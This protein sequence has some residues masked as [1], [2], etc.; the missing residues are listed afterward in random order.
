[1]T[2]NKKRAYDATRRRE[3]A[4]K[5]RRAT[6][7]RVVEAAGHLFVAKGYVGTTM[8]DIA[9]EAGVAMQSVYKAGR[10]KAELLSLVVDR[11]VAGDDEEVL[12]HDRPSFTAI[13][14]EPDA[15]R[16]LA[17]V[18]AAIAE[19]QERSAPFQ[20]AYREAGAVDAGVAADVVA[21]HERRRETFGA[22]LRMVP[23]DRL[24]CPHDQ[25]ADTAWA[26]GSAE[27]FHLLRTIRGWSAKRYRQWLTRT[28]TDALLAG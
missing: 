16:Q 4:E 8:A 15:A 25:A 24:S 13:A 19:V 6:Q 20:R 11:A 18:A 10:S 26:I 27:V 23:A 21:A 2:G 22:V 1:V 9:G 5:E 12:V 3:R 17:L 14:D 7:R 28:L